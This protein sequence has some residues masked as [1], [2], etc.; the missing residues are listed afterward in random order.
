MSGGCAQ[1]KLPIGALAAIMRTSHWE[2]SV[3]AI[4][5]KIALCLLLTGRKLIDLIRKRKW[6]LAHAALCLHRDPASLARCLDADGDSALSWLAY[7]ATDDGKCCRLLGKLLDL[8][9]EMVGRRERVYGFLPLHSA[10]W[11]NAP[12]WVAV[13]LSAECPEALSAES[14]ARETPY[15]LGVYSHFRQFRWP[16]EQALLKQVARA[17]IMNHCA[18]LLCA[19]G[20][21]LS[22]TLDARKQQTDLAN[23]LAQCVGLP[24]PGDELVVRCLLPATLW[25]SLVG[26]LELPSPVG[27]AVRLGRRGAG[28]A[29]R[30]AHGRPAGAAQAAQRGPPP[31]EPQGQ[32]GQRPGG[33]RLSARWAPTLASGPSGRNPWARSSRA[34][35]RPNR[36][37]ASRGRG[38]SGTSA[39]R[40]FGSARLWLVVA[41]SAAEGSG[42]RRPGCG[43]SAQQSGSSKPTGFVTKCEPPG[44]CSN[45]WP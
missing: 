10:A 3:L 30:S 5:S 40:S 29:E 6:A 25:A 31:P 1:R 42:P 43:G 16:T 18:R 39:A 38:G 35:R 13:A 36:A 20:S 9:P 14:K 44:T 26:R 41:G 4:T 15:L 21:R 2:R 34:R 37:R 27:R 22:G 8:A 45:V 23:S 24:L 7:K 33:R 17:T 12:T 19:I 28:A 11:G 32:R